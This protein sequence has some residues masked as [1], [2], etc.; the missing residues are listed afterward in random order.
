M[1]S[2]NVDWK[3]KFWYFCLRTLSVARYRWNLSKISD[4]LDE[5]L[6]IPRFDVLEEYGRRH[7][8]LSNFFELTLVRAGL[9]RAQL[10]EDLEDDSGRSGSRSEGR[11][12]S[13]VV[14]APLAG[15]RARI[16]A[17]DISR[18]TSARP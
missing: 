9:S 17:E 10:S 8:L 1:P 5:S 14:R 7:E 18:R 3:D 12:Q 15:K 13:L 6:V 16:D 2:K 11:S 4:R